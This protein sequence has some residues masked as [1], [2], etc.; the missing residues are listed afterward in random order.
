M[1]KLHR[2]SGL[3]E[4]FQ[5]T[6][7]KPT[8]ALGGEKSVRNWGVLLIIPKQFTN[9]S[10]MQ[11]FHLNRSPARSRLQKGNRVRSAL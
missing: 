2:K 10:K 4:S 11:C 8:E 3:A 5:F 6:F 7:E 1:C 9:V